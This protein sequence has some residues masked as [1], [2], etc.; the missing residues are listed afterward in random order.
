[1]NAHGE[2][3]DIYRQYRSEV[4]VVFALMEVCYENSTVGGTKSSSS[5]ILCQWSSV[6]FWMRKPGCGSLSP[7]GSV[8]DVKDSTW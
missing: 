1:M 6:G 3:T 4:P 8:A 2:N 5:E 7:S